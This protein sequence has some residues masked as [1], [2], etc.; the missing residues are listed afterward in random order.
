LCRRA[1]SLG[2]STLLLGDHN[3]GYKSGGSVAALAWAAATTRTLNVGSFVFANGFRHPA[4]LAREGATINLLS[5]GRFEFGIGAGNFDRD[6]EV[7][8]L[9]YDSAGTRIDRLAEAIS[10]L[11]ASWSEEVVDFSGTHYT[12]RG[13]RSYPVGDAVRPRLM[14]GGAG[15]RIL[16]LAGRQADIVGIQRQVSDRTSQSPDG[17]D[18]GLAALAKE[19]IGWVR[20]AAGERFHEIELQVMCDVSIAEDSAEIAARL[21]GDQHEILESPWHL[22]GSIEAI[23]SRVESIREEFGVTYFCVP[24]SLIDDFAPVVA[25]VSGS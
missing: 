1:E 21:G 5:G 8:G 20:D 12:L 6:Y 4:I 23:C 22:S 11:K 14:I 3:E 25:R 15:R 7:L 2:Y 18:L 17:E 13:Y 10:I 24:D 19:K 16:S 9:D